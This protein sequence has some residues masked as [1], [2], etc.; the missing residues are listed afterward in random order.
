MTK[1]RIAAIGR[2]A[3]RG[4]A[5]LLVG[6]LALTAPGCKKSGKGAGRPVETEARVNLKKIFDGA[7][8]YFE[9]GPRMTRGAE[10]QP[11]QFPGSAP[12]TPAEPCCKGTNQRCLD[13]QWSH[14]SWKALSFEIAD[15]HYCQYQL[16]SSGVKQQAVFTARAVC[17]EHCDG[18]FTVFEREGKVDEQL[19]VVDSSTMKV[20][21]IKSLGELSDK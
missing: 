21:R 10:A 15:P 19:R 18:G 9:A 3:S 13:A 2:A 12:L 14:P 7:R 6:V 1:Q 20:R 8:V 4:A 11:L 16:T 5:A 17:Q